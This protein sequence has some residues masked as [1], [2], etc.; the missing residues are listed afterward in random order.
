MQKSNC[1]VSL[2]AGI[3]VGIAAAVLFAPASGAKTRKRLRDN[4]NRASGLYKESAG[5]FRSTAEDVLQ[6][7][8]AEISRTVSELKDKAKEK[9]VGAADSTKKAADQFAG[10]SK[11]VAHHMGKKMEEAGKR[12]QNA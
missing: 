9:I 5:R 4:A 6:D 12:L 7:G 10:K 1:V 11:D 8:H 2:L 3:G